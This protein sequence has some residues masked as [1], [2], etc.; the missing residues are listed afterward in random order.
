MRITD[1]QVT[2][3]ISADPVGDVLLVHGVL[4]SLV[5]AGSGH[6]NSSGLHGWLDTE[7]ELGDLAHRVF[8]V[9]WVSEVEV[10]Q[11]FVPVRRRRK[12]ERTSF[13]ISEG[14]SDFDTLLPVGVSLWVVSVGS[15][16]VLNRGV[17]FPFFVLLG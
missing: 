16:G 10:T 4:V 11:D 17:L 9:S 13:L 3:H 15:H 2:A 6:V 12:L 7:G 8:K 1:T 5:V 14:I